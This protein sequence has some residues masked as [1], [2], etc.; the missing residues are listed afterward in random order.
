MSRDTAYT[1]W[2]QGGSGGKGPHEMGNPTSWSKMGQLVGSGLGLYPVS[3]GSGQGWRLHN[4]SELQQLCLTVLTG[5]KFFFFYYHS[6][7]LL[8]QCRPIVTC[9]PAMHLSKEPGSIF[10]VICLPVGTCFRDLSV[11]LL[12]ETRVPWA[13]FGSRAHCWLVFS[14]LSTRTPRFF[15]V[16]PP[17][18]IFWMLS[19]CTRPG[20][21][22]WWRLR[23]RWLESQLLSSNL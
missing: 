10:S 20:R 1:L 19:P 8:F 2:L 21:S 16:D 6:Q 7:P 11:L 15:L 14:W 9:L 17:Y 23:Q 4:L 5:R 3:S 22:F 18:F 13:A 12:I